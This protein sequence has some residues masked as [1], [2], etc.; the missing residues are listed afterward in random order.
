MQ[1]LNKKYWEKC[2]AQRLLEPAE[3]SFVFLQDPE[4]LAQLMKSVP[5]TNDGKFVLLNDQSEEDGTVHEEG[6]ESEA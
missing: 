2:A 3:L 5:L 6:E 1:N 4:A